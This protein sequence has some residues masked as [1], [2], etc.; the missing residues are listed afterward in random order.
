MINE[1]GFINNDVNNCFYHF[2]IKSMNILFDYEWFCRDIKC[3]FYFFVFAAF[4]F[5]QNIFSISLLFLSFP[6]QVF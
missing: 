1:D 4:P 3:F 2:N 6:P 5:V